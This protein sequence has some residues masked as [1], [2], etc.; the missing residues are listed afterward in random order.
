MSQHSTEGTSESLTLATATPVFESLLSAEENRKDHETPPAPTSPEPVQPEVEATEQAETE[1]EST[2]TEQPAAP[3]SESPASNALDPST[4]LRTKVDGQE[5]EVTLEEAL[6]GYSRTQDYTRKTQELA[7]KRKGF[8]AEETAVRAERAQAAQY[9][10]QLEQVIDEATPKEPNWDTL[11]KENPARFAEEWAAWDQHKK[12]REVLRQQSAEAEAQVSQDRQE[13]LGR[14]LA[15]EQTKLLDAIPEWKDAEKSKAEKAELASYAVS[16]GYTAEQ[17]GEVTDHRVVLM[18]RKS[19]L[20]DKQQAKRPA[21]TE[22]IE[23]VRTATPGAGEVARA[24]VS[25]TTRRIQ[26]LA[27]TGR[28]EDAQAAFL[29]M[30]EE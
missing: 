14:H 4:K 16:L 30:L 25:E 11:R 12:E 22:R 17:L 20:F 7:D 28:R 13:Q 1:G 26:R 19:M 21:L 24:Q 10:K 5:I 29:S 15:S 9:L 2:E 27:K 23:K 18:L 6:K 3:E 8:E